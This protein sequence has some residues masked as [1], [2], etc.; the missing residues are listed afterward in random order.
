MPSL[1]VEIEMVTPTADNPAGTNAKYYISDH[2]HIGADG[3]YYHGFIQRAPNLK[4][5]DTGSGQIEMSGATIVIS[6]EPNNPNHPFGQ[7]NYAKILSDNGPYYIGIKY[8]S[9]YNLFEGQLFIQTLDSE[10]VRCSIRQ[11]RS[12]TGVGWST[13]GEIQTSGQKIPFYYGTIDKSKAYRD[14]SEAN[15]FDNISG[16][17]VQTVLYFDNLTSTTPTILV[18]GNASTWTS[19]GNVRYS[20]DQRDDGGNAFSGDLQAYQST[21]AY[22]SDTA[23]QFSGTGMQNPITQVAATGGTTFLDFAEFIVYSASRDGRGVPTI[24]NDYFYMLE[25]GS[26]DSNKTGTSPTVSFILEEG[27]VDSFTEFKKICLA[28]NYQ[29]FILPSQTDGDRE[30][31]IIDKAHTPATSSAYYRTV[32]E[33]DV[34]NLVIRGPQEI[35]RIRGNFKYFNSF[36]SAGLNELEGIR[37]QVLDDTGKNLDFD[38]AI[39]GID[40]ASSILDPIVTAM[41]TFY[42]K[43][44]INAEINDLHDDWRPG[45]RVVFNRRDEFVNVDMIIRSIEWNFNDL[46][47]TIEGDATLTPYVQE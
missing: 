20:H 7:S 36:G 33:N 16:S 31:T 27:S 43:G 38:A 34:L 15:L 8:Q 14:D 40:Q 10:S 39:T 42:Q 30:L 45:D 6:N 17:A 21:H 46:T 41:K 29:Y 24:T 4:L 35:N 11:I 2:G 32:S 1:E 5:Q 12:G 28:V 47:T 19:T 3:E 22:P 9:V 44:S 18:N 25:S 23:F 13:G 26:V 37:V